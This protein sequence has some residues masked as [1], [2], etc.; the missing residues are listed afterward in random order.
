MIKQLSLT[1]FKAFEKESFEFGKL[2]VMSGLNNSGKSTVLQAIRI[3]HLNKARLPEEMG[4]LND[5]IRG[6]MGGFDITCIYETSAKSA[7]ALSV[8]YSRNQPSSITYTHPGER[9]DE[10]SDVLPQ[11]GFLSYISAD[12]YGPRISLQLAKEGTV[13]A[14]GAHG[15]H[16][17]DFLAELEGGWS[18]LR[19]PEI[20]SRNDGAGVMWNI[21]EWLR[22]ISPGIDFSYSLDRKSEIGRTEFNNHKAIHAGFGL[23]YSLP[24]ITS[25]LLH[26]A[27]LS[28]EPDIP[29]VLLIENPEA[30]LHPSGQTLM[31][32]MIALGAAA[33][34]QVFVETHS[35]HLLN[36]IRLA[37]KEGSL[38]HDDATCLY[39][40]E[41]KKDKPS[42]VDRISI[43][44]RGMI[45]V[46][47]DGFFDET[48]KNLLQLL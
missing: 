32:R 21:K 36:G 28:E 40:I 10:S 29:R 45:D 39:F 31:G 12:R 27:Q 22:S 43:D 35:D 46:W 5:Y 4:M 48:E 42:S 41:G 37:I 7:A 15:E 34:L 44:S 26:A 30:H 47:P 11:L 3:L 1:N 38:S 24:I 13:D 18:H 8:S 14:V 2:N 6:D 20:L 25:V 33:G 23:S 17:V 19:V 9:G 16:I